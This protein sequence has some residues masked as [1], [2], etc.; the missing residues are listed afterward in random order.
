MEST[1]AGRAFLNNEIVDGSFVT[2]GKGKSQKN[3]GYIVN[4]NN[5]DTYTLNMGFDDKTGEPIQKIVNTS[6]VKLMDPFDAKIQKKI[7]RE[8][9]RDSEIFNKDVAEKGFEDLQKQLKQYFKDVEIPVVKKGGT[10][11]FDFKLSTD[12]MIRINNAFTDILQ[13]ASMMYNPNKRISQ[14]VADALDN[15]ANGFTSKDFTKI[16][17]ANGI[18]DIEFIS[19][20]QGSYLGTTRE[21]AKILANASKTKKRSKKI[22]F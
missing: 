17:D 16:L 13:G 8:I 1:E 6:A 21:S 2:I 3:I 11:D 20:M 18:S 10:V 4:K 14:Q 19:F 15:S 12:A 5:D 9:I 7:Q 22:V